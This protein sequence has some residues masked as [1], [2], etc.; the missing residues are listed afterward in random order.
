MGQFSSTDKKVA[1]E[2]S[3][4]FV[5]HR[6]VDACLELDSREPTDPRQDTRCGIKQG[7]AFRRMRIISIHSTESFWFQTHSASL[8]AR[9]YS[10]NILHAEGRHALN[11]RDLRR[12][13]IDNIQ[14]GVSFA[15]LGCR[16]SKR[17]NDVQRASFQN[18]VIYRPTLDGHSKWGSS[19]VSSGDA[20]WYWIIHR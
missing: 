20:W 14:S 2:G 3:A 4:P 9:K 5:L 11:H 1:L 18:S 12:M 16:D 19:R 15:D 10:E 7:L 17:S 8:Q 13:P 6:D